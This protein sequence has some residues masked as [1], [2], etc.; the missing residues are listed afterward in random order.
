MPFQLVR[1]QFPIRLAF[2][3][4]INKVQ[5]Q[6]IPYMGLDLRNPIFAH[7]QLYMALSRVQAKKNII[8]LVKNNHIEDKPNIYTK[9]IVYKEIF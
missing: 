4:T 3:M 2:A 7:D 9:N 8:I 6:T 1:R 5:G